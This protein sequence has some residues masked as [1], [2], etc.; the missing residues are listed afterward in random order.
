MILTSNTRYADWGGIFGETTIATA[1]LD[2]LLHQSTT[3]HIR[4][5]SHRLCWRANI[6]GIYGSSTLAES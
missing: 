3:I 6:G 5:E 1:I 2:R 4:G